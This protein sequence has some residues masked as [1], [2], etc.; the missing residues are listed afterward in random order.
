MR[1]VNRFP[2]VRA[3]AEPGDGAKALSFFEAAWKASRNRD[4]P[5]IVMTAGLSPD[6]AAPEFEAGHIECSL[7]LMQGALTEAAD[8][9][10]F[11]AP[12]SAD[13]FPGP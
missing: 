8:T 10:P 11:K 13:A 2:S 7:E 4:P 12:Y 6:C 1:S 5:D 3:G 9:E